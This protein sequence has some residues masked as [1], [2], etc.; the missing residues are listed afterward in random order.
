MRIVTFHQRLR[1]I[2]F[3]HGA[4]AVEYALLLT[5]IAVILGVGA[6]ALGIAIADRLSWLGSVI[7]GGS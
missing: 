6:W 1:A 2:R 4:A 5:L 3:E 7:E